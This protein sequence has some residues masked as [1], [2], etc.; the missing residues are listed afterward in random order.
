M[1]IPNR[2]SG[3]ATTVSSDAWGDVP[4]TNVWTGPLVPGKY[5]V[6]VD[7]NGNGRYD[8]SIDALDDSDIEVTGGFLVV[9]EVPLGTLFTTLGMLVAF[10]GYVRF[11]R[12]RKKVR[13]VRPTKRV[14]GNSGECRVECED[15]T[16]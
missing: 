10:T 1:T 12:H 16:R 3:T 13:A 4:A 8:A 15:K 11:K 5:D 9:P 6:V 7:V 14:L 2:I